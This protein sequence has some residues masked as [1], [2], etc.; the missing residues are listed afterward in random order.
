MPSDLT[1][2]YCS[3][4]GDTW[5]LEKDAAGLFVVHEPNLPSGGRKSRMPA[6]E[7]LKR[8]NGPEREALLRVLSE[9]KSD[10]DEESLQAVMRDCP[11]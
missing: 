9:S 8:S 10:L 5:F 11:L 2:L 1:E 6:E 3:P 7:F 4:N